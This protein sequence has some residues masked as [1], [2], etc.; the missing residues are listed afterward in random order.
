MS[1]HVPKNFS[2]HGLKMIVKSEK[3]LSQISLCVQSPSLTLSSLEIWP[4]FM[5]FWPPKPLP[6]AVLASAAAR[7]A[8]DAPS[9]SILAEA[10]EAT[11]VAAKDDASEA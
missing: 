2:R 3:I 10:V 4:F 8:P 11:P 6:L 1:Y 7:A 9:T 5:A